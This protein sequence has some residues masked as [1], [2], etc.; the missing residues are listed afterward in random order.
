[1]PNLHRNTEQTSALL[2]LSSLFGNTRCTLRLFGLLSI[3]AQVPEIFKSPERDRLLRS[4]EVVQFFTLTTY[5]LLENI[6]HLASNKVIPQKAIT[7]K[8]NIT[9]CYIWAA[10]ALFL[11]LVLEIIKLRR[12]SWLARRLTPEQTSSD[13]GGGESKENEKESRDI[14]K[15]SHVQSQWKRLWASSIWGAL[16]LYWSC[17][18]TIPMVENMTGGLGFLADF[19]AIRDTWVQTAK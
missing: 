10:R 6:G 2:N 16:C 1:M 14:P 9:R 17:G 12:E 8:M 3:W 19:F 18:R 11:H 13:R 7:K 4:V 5:Q 15:D